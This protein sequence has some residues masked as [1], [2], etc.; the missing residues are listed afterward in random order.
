MCMCAFTASLLPSLLT[1][2]QMTGSLAEKGSVPDAL[3]AVPQVLLARYCRVED[4]IVGTPLANRSQ[5]EL[6]GVIGYFV[7]VAALRADLSGMPC[8]VSCEAMHTLAEE[9]VCMV[10]Q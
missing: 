1:L 2:Y 7:N 4:V 6:E 10:I 5:A 9:R 3:C 8:D